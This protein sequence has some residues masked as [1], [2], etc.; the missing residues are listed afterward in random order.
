MFNTFM[1]KCL[2][3]A[4]GNDGDMN[5]CVCVSLYADD[6]MLHENIKDFQ[7]MLGKLYNA[8]RGRN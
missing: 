4:C 6:S 8:Q 5:V 1:N 2:R 3:N 7:Q